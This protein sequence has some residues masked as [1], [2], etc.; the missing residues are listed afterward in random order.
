MPQPFKRVQLLIEPKQHEALA[1][2]ASQRAIS[3]AEVTRQ[4]ISLG[5]EAL[6]QQ[7]EFSRRAAAILQAKELRRA[8]L[9][10]RGGKP[11]EIDLVEE[12]RNL[13]EERDEQLYRSRD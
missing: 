3:I 12:L 8:Q 6:E 9:E 13:R 4:A 11:V 2:L 10:R 1:R 5:L 7:D